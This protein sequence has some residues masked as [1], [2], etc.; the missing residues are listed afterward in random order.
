[1]KRPACR[2]FADEKKN[3]SGTL[4]ESADGKGP[5]TQQQEHVSEEAAKMAN[6]MGQDGPDIEGQGTPVQD[7]CSCLH[8]QVAS[9]T[10]QER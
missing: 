4:P 2:T 5:N 3:T 7:V 8:N 1:M 6:I 9:W 10:R